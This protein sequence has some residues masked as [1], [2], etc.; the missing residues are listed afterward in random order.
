MAIPLCDTQPLCHMTPT[1]VPR[2]HFC[3]PLRP[4]L[5]FRHAEVLAFL[6]VPCSFTFFPLYTPFPLFVM[7]FLSPAFCIANTTSSLRTLSSNITLRNSPWHLGASFFIHAKASCTC[8]H[9]SLT[10]T[11]VRDFSGGLVG[12]TSPSKAGGVGLIPGQGAKI[13]DASWPKKTQKE[14]EAVLW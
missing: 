12:E 9:Y 6:G 10:I 4:L 7:P 8:F 5:G 11:F 14:T 13:S 1:L 3:P 2:L